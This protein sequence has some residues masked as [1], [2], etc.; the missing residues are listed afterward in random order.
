M[1]I[2]DRPSSNLDWIISRP[3]VFTALFFSAPHG[4]LL[5]HVSSFKVL[6]NSSFM[7]DPKIGRHAVTLTDSAVKSPPPSK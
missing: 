7:N 4:T 1:S 2:G 5:S 6:Y 3:E